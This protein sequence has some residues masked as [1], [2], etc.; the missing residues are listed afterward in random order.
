VHSRYETPR[1][2]F[3]WDMTQQ[4]TPKEL[5]PELHHSITSGQRLTLQYWWNNNAESHQFIAINIQG[6]QKVFGHLMITVQKT[7]KIILNSFNHL[8]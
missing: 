6:D 8:P 1:I 4:H 3:F 5:Y 7:R 2:A